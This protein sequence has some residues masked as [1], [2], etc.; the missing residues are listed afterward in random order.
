MTRSITIP[1]VP[2]HVV[3]ELASR[4]ARTGRSLQEYLRGT[5]VTLAATPDP[6][7]WLRRVQVRKAATGVTL[8]AVAILADRDADR[9]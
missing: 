8:P 5:L 6:E 4:A 3:S 9:R 2:D 1:D 7:S